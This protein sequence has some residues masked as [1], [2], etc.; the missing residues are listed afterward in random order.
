MEGMMSFLDTIGKAVGDVVDKGKKDV[1][2]FVKIQKINSEIGGMEKKIRDCERQIEQ[3]KQAAGA[4]VIEL[5]RSQALVLPE[6]Q[7][8]VDQ[9]RGFEDQVEAERAAIAAKRADI[10]RVKAE[11]AV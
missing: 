4:R 10:E 11:H 1:E 3:A 2:Q 5:V 6:V 9:V 8:F 7:P